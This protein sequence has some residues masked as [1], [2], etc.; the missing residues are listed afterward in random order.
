MH[1]GFSKRRRRK[2]AVFNTLSTKCRKFDKNLTHKNAPVVERWVNEWRW[3]VVWVKNFPV[4]C[5]LWMK[6]LPELW[7]HAMRSLNQLKIKTRIFKFRH[8][9]VISIKIPCNISKSDRNNQNITIFGIISKDFE[10]HFWFRKLSIFLS[11]FSPNNVW[12][13]AMIAFAW[14]YLLY[15]SMIWYGCG[16]TW[17]STSFQ[18]INKMES[19]SICLVTSKTRKLWNAKILKEPFMFIQVWLK[20]TWAK[21]F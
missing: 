8:I 2:I 14:A 9:R 7:I 5:L 6:Y 13:I 15:L 3:M 16:R 18:V 1:S 4:D 12:S 20:I 17:A 19:D 21:I 10:W 11:Y